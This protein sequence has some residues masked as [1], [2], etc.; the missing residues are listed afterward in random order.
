[1]SEAESKLKLNETLSEIS[2]TLKELSTKFGALENSVAAVSRRLNE[3]DTK[4]SQRCDSI[5]AAMKEKVDLVF[6]KKLEIKVTSLETQVKAFESYFGKKVE[7]LE[8]ET[9]KHDKQLNDADLE[10]IRSEAYSKRFNLLVH[11]LPEDSNVAWE[12]RN[13]TNIIFKKFL[14]EGLKIE[15]P[16]DLPLVD[17]HRL[18]Q[19]PIYRNK[20]KVNRP[21]II[22]LYNNEDK[23]W[24]L[25]HLRHLKEYNNER[26]RGNDSLGSVFV[27]DHLPKI[28]YDQKKAL[29]PLFNLARKE[30]KKTSWGF[31][32][33]NYCL[34]INGK[35]ATL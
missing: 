30:K 31:D 7:D 20:V 15:N 13:T 24:L 14:S 19:H 27:T 16:E 22:K 26:K 34:F 3:I 28:Y 23:R 1:M 9:H 5:D 32:K 11:G 21:I 35:K 8:H 6:F 10:K 17:I 33:G 4:L 2:N 29:M 12:T 25:S 18:P